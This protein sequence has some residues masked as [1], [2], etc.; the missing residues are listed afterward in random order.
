MTPAHPLL[1]AFGKLQIRP[2][3]ATH[4]FVCTAGPDYLIVNKV[5]YSVNCHLYKWSD[6]EWRIGMED[7]STYEQRQSLYMTRISWQNAKNVHPSAKTWEKAAA[8]IT[9][10]VQAF[11]LSNRDVVVAAEREHLKEKMD[12]AKLTYANACAVANDALSAFQ[13][14]RDIYNL[15]SQEMKHG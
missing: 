6:G 5:Q 7:K 10:A 12:S 11:V 9:T 14:A 15:Y 8:E 4:V 13:K 2:T 1:T 3:E